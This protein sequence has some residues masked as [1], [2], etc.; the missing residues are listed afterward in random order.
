MQG[1]WRGNVPAELLYVTYGAAQ[2][3]AYHVISSLLLSTSLPSPA[4]SFISGAAAG[5][6]ATT[7]T[8]P[9]ALLRTRFAAQGTNRIYTSLLGSFNAIA[10]NEGAGGFFQ[11]LGAGLGQIIPYMGMFFAVYESLRPKIHGLELP[12]GSGDAAAGITASLVAK[13]SVFPLDLI[14]K[15]LQIQGPSRHRFAG[16]LVPEYGEGVWLTGRKIITNEGWRGLYRGLGVSLVKAAPA[17]AV[18]MWTYERVLKLL[19]KWDTV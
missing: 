9:L 13:T 8:Y 12:F 18:T 15:R 16:G 19:V 1:F 2:F 17:S 14:R 10:R 11:G 3:P 5:T 4:A 7:L 6:A